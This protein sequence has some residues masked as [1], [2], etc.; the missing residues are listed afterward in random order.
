MTPS[1]HDD[2]AAA[3]AAAGLVPGQSPSPVRLPALD[4]VFQARAARLRQLAPGHSLGDWLEFVAILSDAQHALATGKQ[5]DLASPLPEKQWQSDLQALLAQLQDMVPDPAKP[6]L[7]FLR[8][9]DET[10][11]TALANRI[12]GGTLEADDMI[13]APFIM[14]ALQVAWTRH[15]AGLAAASVTAPATAHSCPVCGSAP[16]AGVIHVGSESGGLRYLHCS[17]CHTAWHHVRAAC[18]AC[19]EGKD[20][21][22]RSIDDH[23]DGARA[24]ACDSC[25]NYLKLLLAE[26][27]PGAPGL[28]PIADDMASLALDI[29]VSEE[30]YQ[31]IGINPF[32]LLG[33]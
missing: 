14:A 10:S 7:A 5:A 20:I 17:L 32:L 22:Y 18:I 1:A 24:E 3:M 21:S 13:S 26:K 9:A 23:E 27:V 30:D 31:R 4:S 25:R 28:D 12:L 6:T 33:E 15:A 16:V 19:G 11:L 29:L 2:T 8:Q